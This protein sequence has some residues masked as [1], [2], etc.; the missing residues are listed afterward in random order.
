MTVAISSMALNMLLLVNAFVLWFIIFRLALG[1]GISLFCLFYSLSI[2][3]FVSCS[4]CP[5]A[6]VYECAHAFAPYAFCV[7]FY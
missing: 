6:C 3:S 1:I 5:R 4:A 7:S 2:I